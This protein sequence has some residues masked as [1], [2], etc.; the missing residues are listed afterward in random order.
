MTLDSVRK[1]AGSQACKFTLCRVHLDLEETG[2]YG[3][4][5]ECAHHSTMVLDSRPVMTVPIQNSSE[6]AVPPL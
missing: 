5:L 3:R 6:K 4:A 2:P 1:I